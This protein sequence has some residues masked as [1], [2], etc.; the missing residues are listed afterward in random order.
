MKILTKNPN[1]WHN[2][3]IVEDSWMRNNNGERHSMMNTAVIFSINTFLH[4]NT[5]SSKKEI[6]SVMHRILEKQR[7]FHIQVPCQRQSLMYRQVPAFLFIYLFESYKL[8]I[9][10][11][12]NT[13][14]RLLFP[15]SG[16]CKNWIGI[17]RSLITNWSKQ[18]I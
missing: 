18:S 5:S 16:N 12:K 13:L 17:K 8:I 6:T 14:H 7:E 10:D 4:L 15:M 1:A 2:K 11:W 3:E 9:Y